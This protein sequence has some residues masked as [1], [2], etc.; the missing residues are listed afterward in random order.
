[1]ASLRASFSPFVHP[2]YP[3]LST[4]KRMTEEQR[5]LN[6]IEEVSKPF[7]DDPELKH[8]M[9]EFLLNRKEAGELPQAKFFLRNLA[10]L[11]SIRY[12]DGSSIW[13]VGRLF[14]NTELAIKKGQNPSGFYFEAITA[15][16]LIYAGFKVTRISKRRTFENGNIE[17]LQGNDGINR[18]VDIAAEKIIDGKKIKFHI[19][20]KSSVDGLMKAFYETK[21]LKALMDVAKS[22]NVQQIVILKDREPILTEDGELFRYEYIS[23]TSKEKKKIAR[24]KNAFPDLSILTL[25]E[26]K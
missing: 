4:P 11:R 21:E 7:H 10:K 6:F 13:K 19:E 24:C 22:H 8:R 17:R 5:L 20:V 14:R 18:E 15:L 23:L 9:W 1:M 2:F 26:N 3:P 12:E 16:E 25:S